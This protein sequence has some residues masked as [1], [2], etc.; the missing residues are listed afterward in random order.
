M[1][2][3]QEV[4]FSRASESVASPFK[5]NFVVKKVG[6]KIRWGKVKLVSTWVLDLVTKNGYSHFKQL[7]IT[8]R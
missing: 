1:N 8:E 4:Q 3:A 5:E 7:S 6:K 2:T